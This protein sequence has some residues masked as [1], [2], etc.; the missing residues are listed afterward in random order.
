AA[1]QRVLSSGRHVSAI[2]AGN[3]LSALGVL[4]VLDAAGKRVPADISLVG[5]DNT[6]VSALRHIALTS[7]E[8]QRHR[9]GEIAV[10]LLIERI[11]GGRTEAVHEV[12]PPSLVVRETTAPPLTTSAAHR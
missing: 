3:D 12:V 7:V 11:E 9:Q 10:R 2:F 5:Y 6:Y 8:Q 4:D 1:A